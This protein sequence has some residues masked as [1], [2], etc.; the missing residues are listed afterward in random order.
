MGARS[1]KYVNTS[2]NQTGEVAA[3]FYGTKNKK[4]SF[5]LHYLFIGE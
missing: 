5:N 4:I 3:L 1:F 2:Q